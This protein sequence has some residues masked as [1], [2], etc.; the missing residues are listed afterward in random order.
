MQVPK[1]RYT[2][3]MADAKFHSQDL[4]FESFIAL[5]CKSEEVRFPREQL[6]GI[7]Q[8]EYLN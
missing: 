7:I 4:W 1:E 3:S 8:A 6:G 5:A 2:D